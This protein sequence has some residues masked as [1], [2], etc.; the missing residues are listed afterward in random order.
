MKMSRTSVTFQVTVSTGD[1]GPLPWVHRSR[2]APASAWALHGVT[3]S[4]TSGYSSMG[5]SMGCGV[6]I[7]S[8]MALHELQGDRLLH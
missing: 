8:P 5:S 2:Q 7:S 3:N 1:V 6:D 4:G